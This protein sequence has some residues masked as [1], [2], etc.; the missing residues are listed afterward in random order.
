M[1]GC[2]CRGSDCGNSLAGM[3][4]GTLV[5]A[6]VRGN[7]ISTVMCRNAKTRSA[8]HRRSHLHISDD[9]YKKRINEKHKVE[10]LKEDI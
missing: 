6:A 7:L 3:S 8:F 9:I 10:M 1:R 2:G 4:G 5:G